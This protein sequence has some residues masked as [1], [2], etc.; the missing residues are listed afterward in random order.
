[1][2]VI[3]GVAG[4][5]R[6]LIELGAQES[7]QFCEFLDLNVSNREVTSRIPAELSQR[8]EQGSFFLTAEPAGI[9]VYRVL[10]HFGS[11]TARQRAST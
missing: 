11:C 4:G 3:C 5:I 7:P 6:T 2:C 8:V 10:G 9:G 1:M